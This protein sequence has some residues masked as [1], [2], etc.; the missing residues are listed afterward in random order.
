MINNAFELY[1][2]VR[3]GEMDAKWCNNCVS[4]LR[5]DWRSI[6]NINQNL[7]NKNYL[8]SRQSMARTQAL[9]KKDSEFMKIRNGILQPLPIMENVKN[10]FVE[11]QTKNPPKAELTAT[12]PSALLDRK[13]DFELF[14]TGPQHAANMNYINKRVGAPPYI[15]GQGRYKGKMD[16]FEGI[17][18]DP[19]DPDDQNFFWQNNRMKYEITGQSLLNNIFKLQRFDTTLVESFVCDILA[20]NVVC[21]DQYVDAMTGEIKYEHIYP[22][23]FYGLFGKTNDGQDDICNGYQKSITVGEWLQKVGDSFIW[24]RDWRKLLWAINYYANQT[25]TGFVING[26][27]YCATVNS[28]WQAEA[29]IPLGTP[30]NV[31]PW[32]L[33]YTYE[34]YMGKIQ[35][36]VPQI[37]S[38]YR[39]KKGDAAQEVEYSSM[40]NDWQ[41]TTQ[42]ETE[43]YSQKSYYQWQNYTSYFIATSSVSQWIYNWGKT[44]FQTLHGANDQYCSGTIHYYRNRGIPPV[45]LVIPYIDLANDAFYKMVWA[46]YEAHP[47]WEVY[48]YEEL[49]ALA[50]AMYKQ[51]ANTT[52]NANS[53]QVQNQF[54][55]LIKYFK[56]NLVKIK[57]IPRV[58]GKPMVNL[59]NTPS[60]EKRG[61]DPIAIAMQ[62]VMQ[63]AENLI[64]QKM[65]INDLRQGNIENAREGYKQNVL[66]TQYSKN[67]TGYVYRDIQ[68]MKERIATNTLLQAQDIIRFGDSIPYKWIEK[69]I[70]EENF[71]G[72]K[73][74][75][76]FSAHRF[77]IVVEDV[78]VAKLKER[79]L[80]AS[81]MALDKGD[82]R[83]GI[84]LDEWFLVNSTEDVK[85]AMRLLT[86]LQI[87][88]NKKKRQQQIQDIQMQHDNAMELENKVQEGKKAEAALVLQGKG[89]DAR[90]TITAATIGAKSKETV[91]AMTNDAENPK[92]QAKAD[93]VKQIDNN[94]ANIENQKSLTD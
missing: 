70:G 18:L 24:D 72:L 83:G 78:N 64:M 87:K 82:G 1:K 56:D 88:A 44:Y 52:G 29:G 58:D 35:W 50:T 80:Q 22:E 65:G 27:Q 40:P 62:S 7:I 3:P 79:L 13:I 2:T 94:K 60:T 43:G 33:A 9:F 41:I 4:W 49:T 66:E 5:R 12:D 71:E 6:I 30:S 19:N 10:L 26:S 74:I 68:Y 67:I 16:G 36:G 91:K 20:D 55:N 75:K 57:A 15:I 54:T 31:V 51:A 37:T 17:Q 93:S 25:Y 39:Y 85:Q 45:Q 42:E 59:N 53:N 76:D 81:D 28:N 21:W 47:D 77:G 14:K 69:L 23:N 92:Q 32:T 90:A 73:A 61:L 11:E 89:I 48:Q 46:V 8:Y 86:Y 84:T 63:L 34:I 38:N